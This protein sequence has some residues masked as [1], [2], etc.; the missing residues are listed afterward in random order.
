MTSARTAAR[1]RRAARDDDREHDVH[2]RNERQQPPPRRETGDLHLD[3]PVDDGDEGE[4]AEV[5]G[6]AEDAPH[7]HGEQH[8]IREREHR[9]HPPAGHNPPPDKIGHI[10]TVAYVFVDEPQ[11]RAHLGGHLRENGMLVALV[12]SSVVWYW[13]GGVWPASNQANRG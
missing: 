6:L 4:D 5:A 13:G 1:P 2:D 7:R 11:A 12:A 9:T 8:V 3:E 10:K